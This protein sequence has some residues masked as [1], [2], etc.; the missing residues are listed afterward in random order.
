MPPTIGGIKARLGVTIEL[1]ARYG[2][3]VGND[4]SRLGMNCQDGVMLLSSEN[5]VVG[6]VCDGCGSGAYSE[7]GARAGAEFAVARIVRWLQQGMPIETIPDRLFPE[8]IGYLQGQLALVDPVDPVSF[9]IHYLLFTM[10]GVIIVGDQG[11]IFASGDG[12]VVQD[13]GITIRDEGNAPR[14]LGYHLFESEALDGIVL[15]DKF[16]I[17]PLET[18][19]RRILIGTDGFD[20]AVLADVWQVTEDQRGLHQRLHTWQ[21]QQARF[22][23]DVTLITVER[24]HLPTDTAELPAIE[25]IDDR[26]D[27]EPLLP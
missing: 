9:V 12:V 8:M 16:D 21:T 17:Y 18:G 27:G 24:L 22:R 10:I 1:R 25:G 15:P 14:Y 2:Q 19:W 26:S 11:L 13:D 4:H 5:M 6:V 7:V 20:P 23:D 3:S